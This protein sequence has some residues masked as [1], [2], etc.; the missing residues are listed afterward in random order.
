MSDA[1]YYVRYCVH[2]LQSKWKLVFLF[3]GFT[4]FFTCL[5]F[6]ES[7][8]SA[9][10]VV[11]DAGSTGT[12]VHVFRFNAIQSF[13]SENLVLLEIPLF[14][15]F[16]GGLSDH[17]HAPAGCRTGLLK[18]LEEAKAVVPISEWGR[19]ELIFMATAGLRLLP[20]EQAEALL[21]EA[22]SVLSSHSEFRV[23]TVDTIDG[24]LEAKLIYVM[25]QFVFK[26]PI[27]IVDLGGGSVQLAYKT[28][29]PATSAASS[30]T[31]EFLET[32]KSHTLYLHSW[33]GFGLVAF[34]L[35]ALEMLTS[36]LPHP[37]VPE[38]TPSGTV[39]HY[40]DTVVPV[41]PRKEGT[42]KR[43]VDV[44]VSAL[45]SSEGSQQ[46][47]LIQSSEGMC[48]LNGQWLGP[49]SSIQEWR[50]FSYIFDIALEEGMVPAGKAEARLTANDFLR[51]AN[52]HCEGP[53]G[54]A[55]RTEW[56]KCIDLTYVFALLTHGFKLDPDFPLMVTKRLKYNDSIE[57]EAAW[58]LGAAIVAIKQE[59]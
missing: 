36:G 52:S 29:L 17:A 56:W 30:L 6:P 26:N 31:S 50:L 20:A 13:R 12:R 51:A 47:K 45:G 22:R 14:A 19:T 18:L 39:Y 35:K 32:S 15:K 53:K 25:A 11:F 46:C 41:T 10:K 55:R 42:G 23:S 44:V 59:L 48:G 4:L 3:L 2:L 33:L 9:Y 27:A 43:C 49:S 16:Q 7:A 1:E 57:L 58:P 37:C 28:S 24:K 38:W 34:R 5:N 21:T 54:L 40:G 8:A